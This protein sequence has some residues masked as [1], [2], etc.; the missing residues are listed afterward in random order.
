MAKWSPWSSWVHFSACLIFKI[1]S[2][3]TQMKSHRASQEIRRQRA[4]LPC[5]ILSHSSFLNPTQTFSTAVDWRRAN[6][7]G[8]WWWWCCGGWWWRHSP[9]VIRP[10]CNPMRPNLSSCKQC[11]CT[12]YLCVAQGFWSLVV[13]WWPP[14][15]GC[16]GILAGD[17]CIHWPPPPHAA[18]LETVSSEDKTLKTLH[19]E[20]K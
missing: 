3:D 16:Y 20:T 9:R 14:R 13:G 12:L 6:S 15:K 8:E 19:K 1:M 18:K 5:H 4:F 11:Q 7:A 10:Q 2:L 17:C